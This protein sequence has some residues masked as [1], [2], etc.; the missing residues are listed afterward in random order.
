M[1]R[2]LKF[3]AIL[4]LFPGASILP[5]HAQQGIGNEYDIELVVFRNH[6]P[7]S[8][9]V[10]GLNPERAAGIEQRLGRLFQRTGSIVAQPVDSG[11]MP[12]VVAR[13]RGH[14]DYEVLQHVT[15]SQPIG[16]ISEVPYVDI[17]ALGLGE[18]SGLRGVARFYHTPLLYI[19]VLLRFEPLFDPLA[20]PAAL[21]ADDPSEALVRQVVTAWF[22]EEK[23]RIKVGEIHY[24]DHP[25]LGVLVGAW[26]V[27]KIPE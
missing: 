14:P 8:T 25:R 3:A 5:T 10:E 22:L 16:L 4:I 18:E 13:L 21:T 26:P 11:R 12:D 19:D 9:D 23:R 27:E 20:E 24:L 15:W 17:S 2:L 7:V 1:K 6:A